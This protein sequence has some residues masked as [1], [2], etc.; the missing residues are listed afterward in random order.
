[1]SGKQCRSWSLCSIWSGSTLFAK[2]NLAQYK[3]RNIIV[4]WYFCRKTSESLPYCEIIVLLLLFFQLMKRMSSTDTPLNTVALLREK[5]TQEKTPY[6]VLSG[7]KGFTYVLLK[8]SLR[9]FFFQQNIDIFLFPHKNVYCSTHLK[10]LA[11][12]LLMIVYNNI[13]LEKQEKY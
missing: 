1:M 7:N 3:R 8:Y 13:F 6:I 4:I 2:T 11:E 9:H 12:M 5:Q 10:V